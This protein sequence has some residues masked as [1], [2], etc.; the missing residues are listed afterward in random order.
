MTTNT[1]LDDQFMQTQ[2]RLVKDSLEQQSQPETAA[3]AFAYAYTAGYFQSM[4]AEMFKL[5]PNMQKEQF[6]RQI[7]LDLA[8]LQTQ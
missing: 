4:A 1:I 7:E 5:L 8:R 3:H 2:A 6:L